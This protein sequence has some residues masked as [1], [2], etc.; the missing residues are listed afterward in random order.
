MQDTYSPLTLEAN[1]QLIIVPHKQG[2]WSTS[3]PETIHNAQCTWQIT[4]LT[5]SIK[6][7]WIDM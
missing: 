3:L 1:S 6:V 4:S 5:N 7:E 2:L